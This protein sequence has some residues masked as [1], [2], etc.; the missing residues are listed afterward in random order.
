MPA[1][2]HRDGLALEGAGE[3]EHPALAVDRCTSSKNVSAMYFA[4]SGSPGRSRLRRSRRGWHERGLACAEAYATTRPRP[5]VEFAVRPRLIEPSTEQILRFCAAAP[6]ERV[7][8]GGRRAAGAGALRRAR[9][10]RR[11]ARRRSAISAATSC[12]PGRAAGRS[13]ISPARSGARMLI[14]EATAVSDLWEAARRGCRS[15]ASTDPASP[16]TRSPSRPRPG[17]TGL[18]AATAGRPR[19]ARPVVRCRPSEELGVDPLRRDPERLPLADA[20]ADRGRTLLALGRGRRDPLQGRGVRLDAG[21]GTAAAG[22][23]RS[24]G[25]PAGLRAAAPSAT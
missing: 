17:E 15:P 22:L 18:R 13:P 19:P 14:G 9:H 21:G 12:R 10:D 11:R 23:D 7:F 6:V 20:G 8:L 3:A 1:R 16:S 5:R 2:L 25:P 24:A 4:R